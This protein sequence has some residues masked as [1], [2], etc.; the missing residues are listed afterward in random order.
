LFIQYPKTIGKYQI[1]FLQRKFYKTGL[2]KR[3]ESTRIYVQLKTI[4]R[5][6]Q[7][8][9]KKYRLVPFDDRLDLFK[10]KTHIHFIDD[11]QYVGWSKYALKG[12]QVFDVPGDQ[13][14]IFQFPHLE[15]FACI[16][17]DA[18]DKC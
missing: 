3:T 2:I 16:L 4:N 8:A 9:F 1:A 6:L 5:N 7:I 15:E 18:L 10:S 12:V 13:K 14:K 11:Q 17:Q